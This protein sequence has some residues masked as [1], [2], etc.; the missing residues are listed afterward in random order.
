MSGS[1]FHE[2]GHL[3]GDFE[4]VIQLPMT[5]DP[6]HML[7]MFDEDTGRFVA[8]FPTNKSMIK[9]VTD[10][11]TMQFCPDQQKYL[12]TATVSQPGHCQ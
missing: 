8:L 12:V 4:H 1:Y 6:H 11:L 7:P 10:R 5:A 3:G 2:T 9:E